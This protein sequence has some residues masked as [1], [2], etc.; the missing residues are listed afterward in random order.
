MLILISCRIGVDSPE[1]EYLIV[2]NKI[3]E[4]K[5]SLGLIGGRPK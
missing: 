2:L 4:L 5:Y 3:L 1:E